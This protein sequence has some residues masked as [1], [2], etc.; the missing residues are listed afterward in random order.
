[1][2]SRILA[3]ALRWAEAVLVWGGLILV[4]LIQLPW[5]DV[6]TS[7]M[8]EP[9]K[10]GAV[11]TVLAAI[12]VVVYFEHRKTADTIEEVRAA[13][14]KPTLGRVHLATP[15]EVYPLLESRMRAVAA[16]SEKRLDIIGMTL[17]T[18][19]PSLEFALSREYMDGWTLRFAAVGSG[20]SSS[21]GLPQA[22]PEEARQNM[23]KVEIASGAAS[24]A[25][26][27]IVLRS[28]SYDYTPALHGFRLANGDL[29]LSVL[30]W[31]PEQDVT[32]EGYSYDFTPAEDKSEQAN[33]A[34]KLFDSWFER[35]VRTAASPR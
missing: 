18:A 4:L 16:P 8:S 35:A 3:R 14:P 25:A 24:F 30:K 10:S 11:T 22:W 32:L 33:A 7:W 27:G 21:V 28:F 6:A 5:F 31:G 13:M 12:L 19:W 20:S 1:M 15:M 26:R 9:A 34:R 2:K 29:F 17:Y 23:A